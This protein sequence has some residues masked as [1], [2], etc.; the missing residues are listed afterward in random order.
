MI[1]RKPT[2]KHEQVYAGI[3]FMEPKG[4][5]F[6]LACCHCGLV[7]EVKIEDVPESLAHQSVY[8]TMRENAAYTKRYRKANEGELICGPK[9]KPL[10]STTSSRRARK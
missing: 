2:Y 6:K 4:V 7:H 5:A 8:L 9:I 10:K 3:P 1:K